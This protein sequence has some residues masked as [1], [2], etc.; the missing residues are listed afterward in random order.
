MIVNSPKADGAIRS[1]QSDTDRCGG[2]E[3]RLYQRY[4]P[5]QCDLNNTESPQVVVLDSAVNITIPSREPGREIPCRVFK[6]TNAAPKAV[7][8]HIH[9]GGWVLQSEAYQDTTLQY[10]ADHM[11]LT[12][13]SGGYR[14]APEH[15]YPAG[16]EDC[17]DIG[18]WL[19]D[20]SQQSFGIPLAFMGGDSAGAHLSVLTA[21]HLLGS[22][23]SFAFSGL[24]LNFGAYDLSGFLPSMHNFDLELVLTH[25]IMTRSI[26]SLSPSVPPLPCY[27]QYSTSFSAQHTDLAFFFSRR[28]ISAYLPSTS[29]S[30]RRD[31]Q[32]SPLYANLK[33]LALPPALFTCGTLDCLLDDSVMMSTKWSMSGAESVLKVYPGAPHGFI[34]FP[35]DCGSET[36]QQGLDDVVTFVTEKIGRP[37]QTRKDTR[38]THRDQSSTIGCNGFF[39]KTEEDKDQYAA[40]EPDE[41]VEVDNPA[42]RYGGDGA[43]GFRVVN[44]RPVVRGGV[45]GKVLGEDKGVDGHIANGPDNTEEV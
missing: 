30:Q 34:L 22:R 26:V 4:C 44:I 3:K 11:S 7:F 23:S 33:T 37:D 29:E 25:E 27:P 35:L 39:A 21:I 45:Q 10:F 40:Y 42:A 14:L 31:P 41:P 18:E 9:G 16:N 12:I 17:F 32:I 13:V 8:Y 6:P 5:Q 1:G 36:V 28:Y 19:V 24:V 38:Q 2:M 20:N 43:P 15:P